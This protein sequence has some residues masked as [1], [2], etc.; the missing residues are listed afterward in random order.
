MI[1]LKARTFQYW[2]IF[3]AILFNFFKM[4][5]WFLALFTGAKS[6]Q[7][8]PIIGSA[9]LNR[10]GLH[11]WRV[12]L[13]SLLVQYRRDLLK[14]SLSKHKQ[15]E[16]MCNGF[17][18]DF[19]FLDKGEFEAIKKE[20]FESTWLL[21]E[22][23]Q[24]ST[25]TR[26]VFLNQTELS[27]RHPKLAAFMANLEL[28]SRIRFV[29]GVGGEPIFSIQAIFSEA[30]TNNDPQMVVHADTF[31]ANAKAWFFLENVGEDDGPFAYVPGSHQ[32]TE[33]RL[34][35]ER[36][37]SISAKY[38]PI[39]Y[40]ARGSFRATESDLQEMGL[41]NPQKMVVPENTLVVADTFGLHCR[42]NSQ[43]ATCRVEI[44][45]TLRR[46]PFLPWVGFDLFSIPY[47]KRRSGDFSI[48]FLSCL[49]KVGL[50]K[51]P[52]KPIG[53]GKIK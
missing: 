6:F 36:R 50:R 17:T 10:F 23:K 43:H 1:A 3:K 13:A 35:W 25:I 29:A 47:I 18:L 7:D 45:A 21:R 41:P 9:L 14:K 26:R 34:M 51:M 20:V 27:I 33:K 16:Y 42:S 52:W 15:A 8:N 12:R 22:M 31:H 4:P 5:V 44:Y 11:F 32:L 40:H 37:Q 30:N 39:V 19:G 38:H 49:A 46:N 2:K 48:F 28:L 24:G 53:F